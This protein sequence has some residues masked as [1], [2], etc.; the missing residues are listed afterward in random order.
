MSL[1]TARRMSAVRLRK[2]EVIRYYLNLD[3][4]CMD[5]VDQVDD[6]E[7]DR[8]KISSRDVRDEPI[9]PVNTFEM[10]VEVQQNRFS[11]ELMKKFYLAIALAG[12][13]FRPRGH[14]Q[15]LDKYQR[16]SNLKTACLGQNMSP[17]TSVAQNLCDCRRYHSSW[18]SVKNG[19]KAIVNGKEQLNTVF[20]G[21]GTI[22]IDPLANAV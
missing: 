5:E 15:K 4:D 20:T 6:D 19:A 2:H 1:F 9:P 7:E 3:E 18:D 14:Y 21:F 17:D 12:Y 10:V 16:R 13:R 22:G 8:F 11:G